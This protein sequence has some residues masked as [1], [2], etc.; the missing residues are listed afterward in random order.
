MKA[1]KHSPKEKSGVHKQN[2]SQ[3]SIA[4]KGKVVFISKLKAKIRSSTSKKVSLTNIKPI[5]LA[6]HKNKNGK[7]DIRCVSIQK[8]E[9]KGKQVL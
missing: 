2:K 6:L 5:N 1:K 4:S 7:W 3:K 8:R 9:I